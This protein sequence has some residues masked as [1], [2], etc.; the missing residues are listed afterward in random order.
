MPTTDVAAAT[1]AE[2]YVRG[3]LPKPARQCR[4]TTE[5]RLADLI[6]SGLLRDASVSSWA[7]RVPIRDGDADERRLY[8]EYRAWADE[9]GVRLRPFFDTRECYCTHT[10]EKRQEL[11]MPALCLALYD[12]DDDLVCVAP[13]ADESATVTIAD[14]LDWLGE[15][16]EDGDEERTELVEPAD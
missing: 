7:K 2:L 4:R 6:A 1:R 12:E 8:D 3:G 10:G 13:H 15:S 9:E 16:A 14:C 5:R 11:V